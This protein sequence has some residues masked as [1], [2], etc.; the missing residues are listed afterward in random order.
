MEALINN[1][2]SKVSNEDTAFLLGDTVVGAGQD[3]EKVFKEIL[4]RLNYKE[5]YIMPG[6][7]F[8]GF[9][10][11]FEREICTSEIDDYYRLPFIVN[12]SKI[13][14]I[15]PNYYEIFVDGQFIVLSHYPIYSWR[16][17][18]HGSYMLHGHTHAK[19]NGKLK[20]RILDLGPESIGNFPLSFQEI[21]KIMDVKEIESPDY[22]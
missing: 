19:I 11:I 2:N 18:G 17:I 20:G 14:S 22:H 13:V 1:W 12:Y 7:H 10:Q 9:K 8:A 21:K 6:N 16:D 3:S 4:S 15:I 5:L